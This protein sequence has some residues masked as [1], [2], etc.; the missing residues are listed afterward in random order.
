[1]CFASPPIVDGP[2]AQLCAI[3]G[4]EA[5]ITSVTLGTD[6][7][8]RIGF[9]QIRETRRTLG[10][11]AR[12]RRGVLEKKRKADAD[13]AGTHAATSIL[14]AWRAWRKAGPEQRRAIE[15]QMWDIRKD[16]DWRYR[17][18]IQDDL[19]T[20]RLPPGRAIHLERDP[21]R[22]TDDGEE[23]WA[24]YEVHDPAVFFALPIFSLDCVAQ[25]MPRIYLEACSGQ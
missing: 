2:L 24:A 8:P 18:R 12:T 1:M 16:I 10:L 25:H 15:G 7:V 19:A 17:Q 5:L 9:V 21:M 13:Q 20:T 14:Q 4:E 22:L 3:G 23:I 11:L 6:I